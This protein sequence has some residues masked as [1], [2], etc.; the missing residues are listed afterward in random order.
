VLC[1]GVTGR[2]EAEAVARRITQ[3]LERNRSGAVQA[4]IG[5][6][7]AE[8]PDAAPEELIREADAAM[9]AAKGESAPR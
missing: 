7:L 9:L 1:D 6:A 4:S 3:A 2:A 5:I 8:H